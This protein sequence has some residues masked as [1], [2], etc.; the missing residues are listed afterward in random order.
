M[1]GHRLTKL[2]IATG[3]AACS[4]ATLANPQSPMST[5]SFAMAG[6]GV[7]IAHPSAAPGANPAMLAADHHDWADDF[8]L[9]L[10]SVNA[11]IADEEE[12][13]D[14]VDD[15]QGV[16]DRFQ[17]LDRSTRP[18]EAQALAA[19]LLERL[20]RFD[21]DTARVNAGLGLALAVPSRS[22]AFGVF[23]NANLV[24]TVRGEFDEDDRATLETLVAL[25]PNNPADLLQLQN[26]DLEDDLQSRGRVLAAAVFEAGIS[27]AHALDLGNGNRLQIGISPKYVELTTYQYTETVSGFEDEDFDSDDYQTDKSGFNL[28]I[29]AA[30]A[31]G[32]SHQ[33]NLGLM[34]RN[35]IPMELDSARSKPL[36]EDT[37]TL[38]LKP[39]VTAGI[40]HRS[41]YHV[42]TAELDLT[43]KDA[44]GYED[45]T[46]WLALG[47]EFDA[48]R[49]AQ[50][51]L[52]V[53]HNLAGNDD[54]DGIAED[55]QFTAGLGLNLLGVHLDLGALYSDA[56]IGA[57]LELGTAF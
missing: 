32:D 41:E 6:T 34:A 4:G 44:F 2:A 20:D 40:A 10:P 53:R 45:D 23:T 12:T 36:L 42:V 39:M 50:L 16:I 51:R 37:H 26:A 28:D 1:I 25:D 52:G 54:N 18:E 17:Q 24:A 46:Q 3:L 21:R 22:L 13:V 48:W 57:A 5:R 15:I 19:E 47:A 30:Y 9:M 8:G 31:F 33:W 35:L 43:R 56:D 38:E 11:R 7:A 27:V 14:Q 29:G 49:Y 55:T